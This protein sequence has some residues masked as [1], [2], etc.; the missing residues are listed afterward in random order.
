MK[1]VGRERGGSGR[2]KEGVLEPG[3]DIL[4]A[5]FDLSNSMYLESGRETER[6]VASPALSLPAIVPSEL[7]SGPSP[8]FLSTLLV[9]L[10]VLPPKGQNPIL[11]AGEAGPCFRDTIWC[12]QSW[13]ETMWIRKNK[14]AHWRGRYDRAVVLG[15]SS[16][17][18]YYG[19]DCV[20]H[21]LVAGV[22]EMGERWKQGAQHVGRMTRTARCAEWRIEQEQKAGG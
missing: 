22:E 1:E 17:R 8:L 10:F 13:S 6:G 2:R 19:L 16:M 4:D 5:L 18:L 3:V 21:R 14:D 15:P 12:S 9:R 7:F 11:P 20:S